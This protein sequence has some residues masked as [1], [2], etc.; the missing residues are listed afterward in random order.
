[1]GDI[2][3]ERMY[4]SRQQ[5]LSDLEG[6]EEE[7]VAAHMEL[8]EVNDILEEDVVDNSDLAQLL[9][10][11]EETQAE[12]TKK[13]S[14]LLNDP[15]PQYPQAEATSMSWVLPLPHKDEQLGGR[16]LSV[17]PPTML[18]MSIDFEH[19]VSDIYPFERRM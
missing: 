13:T 6:N 10:P 12:Q 9:P 16:T 1:M 17:V 18:S 19:T 3:F 7:E 11:D 4:K 14:I 15:V 5:R 8:N 2:F